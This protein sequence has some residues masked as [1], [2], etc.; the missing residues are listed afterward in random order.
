MGSKEF[1]QECTKIVRQYADEHI[2]KTDKITPYE[3]YVVW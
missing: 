3:V 1:I 2:D